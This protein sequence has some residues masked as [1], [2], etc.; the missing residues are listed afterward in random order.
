MKKSENSKSIKFNQ[1]LIIN[2]IL[3]LLLVFT[4]IVM[5]LWI[6]G[7]NYSAEIKRYEYKTNL[8][9]VYKTKA[10]FDNVLSGVNVSMQKYWNEDIILDFVTRK[11]FDK[12]GV[13]GK[14]I[15][16]MLR[17][18]LLSEEYVT[19]IQLYSKSN[20]MLIDCNNG[21]I[22]RY[23]DAKFWGVAF[24]WF[25]T[26][27]AYS[28]HALDIIGQNGIVW[29]VEPYFI[30]NATVGYIAYEIDF[31]SLAQWLISKDETFFKKDFFIINDYG[32]ILYYNEEN[33]LYRNVVEGMECS[34]AI[35]SVESNS[36][37]QTEL[38]NR[39][40]LLSRA[41]SDCGDWIYA[42]VDHADVSEKIINK[43]NSVTRV[44]FFSVFIIC[45]ISV[46]L[47]T[48]VTY[49]PVI[50]IIHAF[51]KQSP[52]ALNRVK[53]S[54]KIV[55]NETAYIVNSMMDLF[56][57][58]KNMEED[59]EERIKLLNR[60]QAQVLQIQTDP[61][62]LYNSL[63]TIKWVSID[64]FGNDN[65][66][67]KMIEQLSSLYRQYFRTDNTIVTVREEIEM[68]NMYMSIIDVRFENRIKFTV[69][70]PEEL[71]NI[72]CLKMCLQPIVENSIQHGLRPLGYRGEISVSLNIIENDTLEFSVRDTGVGLSAADIVSK[73][74]EL[75][76]RKNQ[77][78]TH[79]G[80]LNV[81][82]RIKLLYGDEY[83]L[84]VERASES[85]KGL[86]TYITFPIK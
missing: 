9:T 33:N 73:N 54:R 56:K 82:E 60:L 31:K 35:L 2:F 21:F 53:G 63:D 38:R 3:V 7:R 78:D 39:R 59:L 50:K 55:F 52:D 44:T 76:K 18:M 46:L 36:V 17:G 14:Q 74:A 42:I 8:D 72:Q 61:H 41:D 19:N 23:G 20:E 16:S 83:G 32:E 22:G 45:A 37:T 4:P 86:V 29:K 79:I 6:N 5:A 70:V 49:L 26:M 11:N 40:V 85:G 65:N 81:N 69:S 47:I 84:R 77:K 71:M 25:N 1:N 13:E 51:T 30:D 58:N 27:E 10:V 34:Q 43:I 80:L 15:F 12:Q 68:L 64:E 62:F 66:T 48:T 67:A 57:N 28:N 75:S 24:E